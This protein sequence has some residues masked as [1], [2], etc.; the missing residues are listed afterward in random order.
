MSISVVG[1]HYF[2]SSSIYELNLSNGEKV[3]IDSSDKG[4]KYYFYLYDKDALKYKKAWV[5]PSEGSCFMLLFTYCF[6]GQMTKDA[7]NKFVTYG[8]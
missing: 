2:A 6:T 7:I 5:L 8:E 3:R 1:H 4:K